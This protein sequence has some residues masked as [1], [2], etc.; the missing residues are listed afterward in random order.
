MQR[1]TEAKEGRTAIAPP[2]Y[3]DIVKIA[4]KLGLARAAAWRI[5]KQTDF[6]HHYIFGTRKRRWLEIEVDEWMANEVN[7]ARERGAEEERLRGW[8]NAV[9]GH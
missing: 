1:K 6:P 8:H 3:I 9:T 7:R 2:G 4:E 5:V